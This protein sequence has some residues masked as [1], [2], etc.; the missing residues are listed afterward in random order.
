V[1]AY[2]KEFPNVTLN[3]EIKGTQG[4]EDVNPPELV[5]RIKDVIKAEEFPHQQIIFPSFAVSE[6]VN[7]KR[8]MPDARCAT[9]HA[10]YLA[11]R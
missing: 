2:L 1:L 3:I 6:I 4:T 7:A 10:V 9:R 11:S 8:L 5:Q